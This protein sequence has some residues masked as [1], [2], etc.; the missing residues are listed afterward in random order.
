MNGISEEKNLLL[1]EYE[2]CQNTA[3]DIESRIWKTGATMWLGVIGASAYV[4]VIPTKVRNV[5]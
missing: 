1:R 3:H 2:L 5:S 4:G